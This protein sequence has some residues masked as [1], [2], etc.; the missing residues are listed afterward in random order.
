MQSCPPPAPS[1]TTAQATAGKTGPLQ[2]CIEDQAK[3]DDVAGTTSPVKTSQASIELSAEL[4]DPRRRA[5]KHP[6]NVAGRFARGEGFGNMPGPLGQRL[7]PGTKIDPCRG[8]VSWARVPI[9]HHNL[10]PFISRVVEVIELLDRHSILLA[11][12]I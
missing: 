7:E 1:L 6:G 9:L 8:D 10:L 2:R 12:E 3:A 4:A 11:T 5:T